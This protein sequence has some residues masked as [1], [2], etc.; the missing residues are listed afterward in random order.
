VSVNNIST[1]LNI[2]NSL[3]KKL[4]PKVFLEHIAHMGIANPD[5]I[6]I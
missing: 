1:I 2:I 5:D 3:T 6:L 4:P